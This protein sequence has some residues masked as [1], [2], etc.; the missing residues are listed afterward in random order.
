MVAKK[1]TILLL[2]LLL[3]FLS[4]YE[5]WSSC[6]VTYSPRFLSSFRLRCII[7]VVGN[8]VISDILDVIFC[9]IIFI[10]CMFIWNQRS[11]SIESFNATVRVFSLCLIYIIFMTNATYRFPCTAF[12]NIELVL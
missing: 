2:L 6:V 3:L 12:I 9:C 7:C 10:K 1:Q 11:N 4:V 8:T 5:V